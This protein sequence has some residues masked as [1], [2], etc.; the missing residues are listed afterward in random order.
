MI[1][2]IV[3][4]KA[5]GGRVGKQWPGIE[6]EIKQLFAG[7]YRVRHTTSPGHAAALT[8][9]ELRLGADI[10]VAV[11]GDG[12]LHEVVNGFFCAG[13]PVKPQA[14]VAILCLGT[15]ADFGRSLNWPTQIMPALQR[16]RQPKIRAIDVGQA[17]FIG[18]K[19]EKAT[20]HFINILDFGIGGAVVA[21]VNRTTKF[22]GGRVSFFLAI[23]ATLLTYRNQLVSFQVDDGPVCTERLNNFIVANGKFFGGGLKPAPNAELGDG[24]FDVVR[25]GDLSRMEAFTN[26]PNLRQG[27]HLSQPK[28]SSCRA[29][30]I[31]A[32]SCDNS[33]N[34]WIDMDGELVGR[35]PLDVSIMP[36]ALRICE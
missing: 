26:L 9:E 29:R 3:N 32:E 10:V 15:G 5:G 17:Q 34:V 7:A 35:L 2:F 11:G 36:Q 30:R 18:C 22:F 27:K 13:Q 28:V 19:G 25:L 8:Q 24:Y 1:V 16:L 23:A 33:E 6:R 14:A 21:R 31:R 12:T 20:R 4:P